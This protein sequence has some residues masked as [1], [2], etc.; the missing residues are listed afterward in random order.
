METVKMSRTRVA[1]PPPLIIGIPLLAALALQWFIPLC[2]PPRWL[3]LMLG[4]LC[5]LPAIVL[6]ASAWL[7]FR[8]N[9]TSMLFLRRSRALVVDGPFKFTRNPLYIG[10]ALFYA[11]ISLGVSAGWPLLFLPIIIMG[12][13]YFAILPEERYLEYRHGAEYRAFKSRVHRWL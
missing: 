12:L 8:R 4:L 6:L 10:F 7:A 5:G 2:F 9:R 1:V 3:G 11:G 13:H